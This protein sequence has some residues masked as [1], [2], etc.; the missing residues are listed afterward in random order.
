MTQ[1][2]ISLLR[3]AQLLD[4]S[5]KALEASTAYRAFLDKEPRNASAWADYA[6]QL[7]KLGDL[8]GAQEACETALHLDPTQISALINLGVLFMRRKRLQ[9]AE[10][11]FRGVLALAP[12]RMDA[13][14][15]LAEC[16][17]NR[18]DLKQA[19]KTLEIT[20]RP[21]AL[22]GHFAVLKPR[23]AELWKILS[24]ALI[25]AQHLEEAEETCH[26]TLQLDP[27]NFTAISNLGSIRMAQGKLAEA[28]GH[29]S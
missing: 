28:E 20:N 13:A 4:L 21:E 6:G 7:L 17:L 8:E 22:S 9:E 14:L 1:K 24:S 16:L 29:I 25:E 19:R 3:K 23:H 27:G 2:P 12:L 5:G 18:K 15:F 10:N 26:L 11:Q